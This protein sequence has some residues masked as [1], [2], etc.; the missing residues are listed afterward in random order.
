M[1]MPAQKEILAHR[2]KRHR[3]QAVIASPKKLTKK[4]TVT[5]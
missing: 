4:M 2:P 1:Y 5:N 3:H